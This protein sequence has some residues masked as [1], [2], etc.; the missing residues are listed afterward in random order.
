[1]VGDFGLS[2]LKSKVASMTSREGTEGVG[3]AAGGGGDASHDSMENDESEGSHSRSLLVTATGGGG[4]PLYMA[5]ESIDGGKVHFS[6]DVWSFG[7]ML[8]EI[9]TGTLLEDDEGVNEAREN[10]PRFLHMCIRMA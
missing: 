6:Q 2:R 1:M 4:T 3:P 10:T 8:N 7:L 5:P 9:L